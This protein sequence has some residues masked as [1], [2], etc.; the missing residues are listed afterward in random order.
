M[1]IVTVLGQMETGKDT[2]ADYLITHIMS[3]CTLVPTWRKLA[4][5]YN[6]KKTLSTNFNISVSEIEQWKRINQKHPQLNVTMRQAL[7][8][9]GD[10]FRK[11]QPN[12][13]ESKLLDEI[14]RNGDK[15]V[16]CDGR[17]FSEAVTFKN[18][19]GINVLLWRKDYEN[20]LQNDSEQNLRPVIQEFKQAG[21]D[22]IVPN[23][24]LF[25]MFI[26]NEGTIQDLYQKLD[27]IVIPYIR[28][29]YSL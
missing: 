15:A 29:R 23:N 11:I 7:I 18:Q 19:E 16:I 4:L 10:G 13:W 5:A 3:H 1:K 14:D 24:N 20:D 6:V 21:Y 26:R 8:Q 27:N 9:I 25:D 17:Y 22:G 28:E 12:I 2:V